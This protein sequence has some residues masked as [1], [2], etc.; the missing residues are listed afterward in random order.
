[1]KAVVVPGVTDQNKGDQALVWESHRLALDTELFKNIYLVS[2]GDTEEERKKLCG[3]SE[4]RGFEFIENILKHPRRGRGS[5]RNSDAIRE[6]PLSFMRLVFNAV[7]DFLSSSLLLLVV[8]N[9]TLLRIFFKTTTIKSIKQLKECD[10]FFVKGG[11]FIHAYGEMAAPYLMWFFLYYVRLAF[12]LGKKVVFLPNSYGPF[13]GLT[14]KKQV[15]TVFNKIDLVFARENLSAKKI[16]KLLEVKIPVSPDL[17]F[18]L[19]KD[20]S[21]RADELL[22]Q[23]GFSNNDNIVGI[24]IRPWR[25]PGKNNG[26]ELFSSYINSVIELSRHILNK[27]YKI[28]LCNQSIGPNSHEDDRNAIKELLAHITSKDIIW[29]NEDLSSDILKSLY[30]KFD[31]FIGTRFHSV[32]FSLTSKV[33]SIAI[34]YGGN[35]AK[36][37][38]DD[39]EL[40]EYILP[41]D[42]VKGDDLILKFEMLISNRVEVIKRIELSLSKL[43][44]ERSKLLDIIKNELT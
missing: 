34:G 6:S 37:I 29:I 33:P 25:F 39:F 41:I 21:N 26:E 14:V 42:E 44:I 28:A 8:N 30:S 31:Y 9:D 15:K 36:G 5:H 19:K 10:V 1:M 24:T 7:N 20:E 12:A 27:G 32:I 38:M 2:N 3:Q 4:L 17:G 35:K 11:G 16:S 22:T 13:E 40:G 18:Y 23:Y 43:E